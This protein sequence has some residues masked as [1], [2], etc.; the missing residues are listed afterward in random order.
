MVVALDRFR[1]RLIVGD[2][3]RTLTTAKVPER[4]ARVEFIVLDKVYIQYPS[5]GSITWRNRTN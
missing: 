5:S 2:R 4:D 1:N 3:V